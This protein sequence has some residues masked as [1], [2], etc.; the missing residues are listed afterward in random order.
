MG[1]VQKKEKR[2]RSSAA[3]TVWGAAI[4]GERGDV[5]APVDKSCGLACLTLRL[6][7]KGLCSRRFL[8]RVLGT[9]VH[10]LSFRRCGLSILSCAYSWAGARCKSPMRSEVL[11]NRVL[12]ELLLL[13]VLWPLWRTNIKALVADKL[14]RSDATLSTGSVA[15]TSI[16]TSEATWLFPERRVEE[17]VCSKV[18]TRQAN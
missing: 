11:P 1:I 10:H 8:A 7:Q 6:V 3:T 16:D 14:L 5:G 12:D 9:W 18:E 13:S 4:D 17:E 15:E 2:V